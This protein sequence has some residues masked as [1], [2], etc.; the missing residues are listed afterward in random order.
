MPG[1]KITC[2]WLTSSVTPPYPGQPFIHPLN[3]F[4]LAGL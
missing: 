1:L 4:I 2:Y 3:D